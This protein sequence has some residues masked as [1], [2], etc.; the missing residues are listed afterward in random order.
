MGVHLAHWIPDGN[1]VFT[2]MSDMFI[3]TCPLDEMAEVRR[4]ARLLV[5]EG[6]QDILEW[7]GPNAPG[8]SNWYNEPT[9][10]ELLLSLRAGADPLSPTLTRRPISAADR[11][12]DKRRFF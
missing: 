12:P 2:G 10:E 7:L 5:R 1:V 6:M 3:G 9:G 4:E 8:G 11:L